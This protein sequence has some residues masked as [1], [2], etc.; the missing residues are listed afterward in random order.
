MRSPLNVSLLYCLSLPPSIPRVTKRSMAMPCQMSLRDSA[1]CSTYNNITTLCCAVSMSILYYSGLAALGGWG[2]RT[3]GES[4][5]YRQRQM[6][7][8]LRMFRHKPETNESV[9]RSDDWLSPGTI[10]QKRLC[11]M[12]CNKDLCQFTFP[13]PPCASSV[14]HFSAC[15]LGS[16]AARHKK[17]EGMRQL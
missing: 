11:I 17:G 12:L 3:P 10:M 5:S 7:G 1:T 8:C 14:V 4:D 6:T 15:A 2:V 16:P 9:R 13:P